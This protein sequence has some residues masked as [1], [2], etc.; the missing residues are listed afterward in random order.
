MKFEDH[1][2]NIKTDYEEITRMDESALS[3]WLVRVSLSISEELKNA[4][5]S[6]L[7]YLIEEAKNIVRDC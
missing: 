3:D 7:C 5:K 6:S 2:G 4:R 1:A